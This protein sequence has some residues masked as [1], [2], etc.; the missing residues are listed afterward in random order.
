MSD[1]APLSRDQL[2]HA[3]SKGEKPKDQWRIGA[4]H[5]KF[6]FAKSTLRRP[7]YEGPGGIK[8]MLDGL[9]RLGCTPVLAGDHVTALQRKNAEGFSA[10]I[11]LEPRGP[12]ALP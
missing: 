11:S 12:L 4:E 1:T 10:S 3:M 5:E 6:G 2:I 9:T 7:A 8:A